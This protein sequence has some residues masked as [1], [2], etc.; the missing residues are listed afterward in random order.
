MIDPIIERMTRAVHEFGGR[1]LRVQGDGIKAVF[2]T[3][4]SREDHALRAALAGQK[5]LQHHRNADR[6]TK[7][8]PTQIR[9]GIH[10]GYAIVRWQSNDFGGGMDTVGSVAHIAAK[11]QERADKDSLCVSERTKDLILDYFEFTHHGIVRL[12][13]RAEPVASFKVE[14][15]K[16]ESAATSLIGAVLPSALVGRDKEL[17]DFRNWLDFSRKDR[18][19]T[20]SILGE[21]GVGKSRLLYEI[22]LFAA[23]RNLQFL[24]V[25]GLQ[26][27]Q[28]TPLYSIA[29]LLR[30]LLGPD[31]NPVLAGTLDGYDLSEFESQAVEKI[32]AGIGSDFSAWNIV[33]DKKIMALQNGV[34]KIIAAKTRYQPLVLVIEDTHN[35]DLDSLDCFQHFAETF[36]FDNFTMIFSSRP[37]YP[38]PD[39]PFVKCGVVLKP[40]AKNEARQIILNLM[41]AKIRKSRK[42]DIDIIVSRAKG[43]PLALQE[44]AKLMNSGEHSDRYFMEVPLEIEP[45][46]RGRLEQ[47][48]AEA[49]TLVVHASVFG[50]ESRL[51]D[52]QGV[53]DWTPDR[54]RAA[55]DESVEKGIFDTGETA[56]PV[57]IHDLFQEVCYNG[58]MRRERRQIHERI[59]QHITTHYV[60]GST[61]ADWQVLARHAYEGGHA[62]LALKHMAKAFEDANNAGT[63]RTVRRLYI[64]AAEICDSLDDGEFQKFGFAMLSFDATQRLLREAKL[65]PVFETALREYDQDLKPEEKILVRCHIGLIKWVSGNPKAALGYTGAALDLVKEL[66]HPALEFYSSYVHACAEFATGHVKSA[67]RRLEREAQKLSGENAHKRWGQSISIPGVI[68]RAFGAWY[69]VDFGDMDL[70]RRLH[71]EAR[72][73]A[74]ADT[75]VYAAILCDLAIGYVYYRNGEFRKAADLLE[76]SYIVT[77][78]SDHS[79]APM[80]GA[81]AALA[82][83]E[84]GELAQADKII[85][86]EISAGRIDVMRNANTFYVLKAQAC[87]L[88]KQGQFEDAHHKLDEAIESAHSAQDP[89]HQAYG[90]RKKYQFYAARNNSQKEG[91]H[92]LETA[93]RLARQ[94]ELKNLI[95]ECEQALVS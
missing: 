8:F 80:T 22:S 31:Q 91:Q 27:Y 32:L 76:K 49:K 4:E 10:S 89:V 61:F 84:L 75:S 59:Y 53:L 45:I 86:N 56:D 34:Q 39:L 47:L 71:K 40:L 28:D 67:V 81:W 33:L 94:C 3:I 9:V 41:D 69:A 87:L 5:I 50:R 51:S 18:P 90:Y 79:L 6:D 19:K 70:A 25:G 63:F 48:S 12:G 77:D 85:S 11:I 7:A 58:M 66:H 36:S 65:L 37:T 54:V 17:N 16:I 15:E 78:K 82:F 74:D 23:A 13:E 2:G 20:L 57:F 73:V 30:Q 38:G 26:V 68:V 95:A 88:H 55:Y 64:R 93:L 21:A 24:K 83:L 52:L 14:R 60:S 1:V 29:L 42:Q 35:I 62:Q 43:S 72:I 46:L 92:C 44:L